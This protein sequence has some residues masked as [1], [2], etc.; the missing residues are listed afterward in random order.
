MST[1]VEINKK[2]W[3]LVEWKSGGRNV[4]FI[5]S[6]LSQVTQE[7]APGDVMMVRRRGEGEWATLV[8]RDGEFT[9]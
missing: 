9:F 1:S 2:Q 8:A 5:T 7:L 4:V 6:V 3:F